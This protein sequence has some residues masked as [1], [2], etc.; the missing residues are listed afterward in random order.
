MTGAVDIF[1]PI[2]SGTLKERKGLRRS[3]HAPIRDASF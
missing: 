1:Y 3:G 2:L